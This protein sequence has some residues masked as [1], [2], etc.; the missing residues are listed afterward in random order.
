MVVSLGFLAPLRFLFTVIVI[1]VI[2]LYLL[3]LPAFYTVWPLIKEKPSD[4]TGVRLDVPASRRNT[5]PDYCDEAPASICSQ[6]PCLIPILLI[7]LIVLSDFR[8]ALT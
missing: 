8:N 5:I 4:D 3:P 7:G 1:I 6:R 2:I